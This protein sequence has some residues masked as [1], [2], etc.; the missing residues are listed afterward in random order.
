MQTNLNKKKIMKLGWFI[1]IG[2]LFL[3]WIFFPTLFSWWALHVW[4]VPSTEL[5][6]IANLGPL[7]DIYGSLNTLISSLALCA[8]AYSAYLQ[9]TSLNES[10]R[11]T[12]RQLLLAEKNHLEQ[13]KESKNAIFTNQFYSLLNYK[14]VKFDSLEFERK[15]PMNPKIKGL[16]ALQV[17]TAHFNLYLSNDPLYFDNYTE[18]EMQDEFLGIC[19]GFFKGTISPLISY[20]Y[21]Y[22]N[23]LELIK[24]SELHPKEQAFYLDVLSNSMFQEEQLFIFWISVFNQDLKYIFYNS[25]LLNQIAYEKF[26]KNYG[27]KFHEKMTFRTRAWREVFNENENPT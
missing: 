22:K 23:L 17:L 13:L 15:L 2:V 14:K 11:S 7:G 16:E 1:L 21:L 24:N 6:S 27:L 4:H 12:E 18:N 8:V 25:R 9:V 26:Y 5:K 19:E 3:I 10:R 20:F